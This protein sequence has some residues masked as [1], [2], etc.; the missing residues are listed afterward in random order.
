MEGRAPPLREGSEL[1]QFWAGRDNDRGG[2]GSS[3]Q[4]GGRLGSQAL[5]MAFKSGNMGG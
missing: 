3:Q 2:T 5:I 1:G 4:I